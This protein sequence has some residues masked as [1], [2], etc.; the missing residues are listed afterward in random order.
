MSPLGTLS[1]PLAVLARFLVG[2]LLVIAGAS[3]LSDLAGFAKL[4]CEYRVL[5]RI[6]ATV[7]GYSLP[8]IEILLGSALVFGIA[9]PWA[10]L[11]ACFLF[12]SFAV[13]VTTN[14]LRKRYHLRCGCFGSRN[15]RHLSMSVM[16]RN[17]ALAAAA[18][19]SA[20]PPLFDTHRHQIRPALVVLIVICV[21]GILA[22]L[23]VL[24]AAQKLIN[25]QLHSARRELRG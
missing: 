7:V 20:L 23:L 16:Y 13:A 14:L 2:L 15:N 11:G 22:G 25:V 21:G 4:V 12:A 17:I 3:K 8:A 24:N 18:L 10:S 9:Q 6:A 1:W 19:Y 5:P